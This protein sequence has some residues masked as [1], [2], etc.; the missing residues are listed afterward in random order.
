MKALRA[1]TL[2]AR[3]LRRLTMAVIRRPSWFLWPQIFLA[4]ACIIITVVFLKFDPDQ[5]DLVSPNLKYQHNFLLLQKAFP[6]QGNDLLV[7]A[8]SG[9]PE[10]NRQFIERLAA[11]MIPQTNLFQDVFYEHDLAAM[12]TKALYFVPDADLDSIETTLRGELPFIMQFTQT[13]NLPTFFEQV[14]TMF[15][16]APAGTN[17]QT[18][19]LIQALPLL[20]NILDQANMCMNTSGKPPSPGVA[21][22]F[23]T[24]SFSDIYVTFDTN[25]VF[26]LTTHPPVVESANT[27]PTIWSLMKS[28][29]SASGGPS[30]DV[31]GDAIER[32]RQ[33][34][35]EV[36]VEVPGVNVG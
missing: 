29:F 9:S 8:Q 31:T 26:L 5:N 30:G 17:S 36:Q 25:R 32:L 23:S 33:L 15:R 13:S 20:A 7:V 4:L 21:S 11:K 6:E 35:R 14:N 24:N 2:T 19:S 16:T 1:D 18:D 10:K 28:A 3:V 27:L 34:I 12:G 22:L